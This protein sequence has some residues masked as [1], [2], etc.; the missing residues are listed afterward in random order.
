MELSL[1][2]DPHECILAVV[3]S[4]DVP[5]YA[6]ESLIQQTILDHKP[7]MVVSG[8]ANGVDK[9]GVQIAFQ[10]GVPFIE[11]VPTK[12]TWD[13]P[14]IGEATEVLL[15]GGMRVTVPGGFKQR[16][17]MVAETCTCLV[18]IYSR[19]TKTYG[20]GWVADHAETLGK[21][22]TRHLVG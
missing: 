3:G 15:D 7:K 6:S 8:G 9:H 4:R 13:A 5:N 19:T 12:F 11:F 22:V 2:L 17:E 18:R 10:M 16:N 1:T 21:A 20:S 14:P